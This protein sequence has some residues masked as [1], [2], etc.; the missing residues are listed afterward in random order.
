[1]TS[2]RWPSPRLLNL[3][4]AKSLAREPT[5]REEI[6]G[7]IESG[8]AHLDDARNGAISL[9]GRFQLV[10][11]AAH[12]FA[13]AALRANDYRTAS[14]EGHRILV[15]QVLA[16]S[17]GAPPELW[18]TLSRAHTKRNEAE[19]A[20]VVEVTKAEVQDLLKLTES[21]ETI[22]TG[23]IKKNRPELD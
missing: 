3:E 16:D 19:Y 23:W 22:V 21:L 12:A 11:M 18:L 15:F 6:A 20:G 7:F 4:R 13:L 5:S 10:Y 2:K 8:R 1:M 9:T 17:A 14:R